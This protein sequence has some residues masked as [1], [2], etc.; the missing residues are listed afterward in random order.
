MATVVLSQPAEQRAYA[1]AFGL[2]VFTIL[3]N[4]TEGAVS[5]WLG[6]RDETLA[7]FGFGVDSFIEV[8]SGLGIAYMVVR[9]RRAPHSN[10]GRAAG[11]KLALRITG[12]GFYALVAGLVVSAAV[13]VWTGHRPE[14]TGWGVVISL[15]SIAVMWALVR[16][17]ERV[18]RQLNSAAIRAS[19]QTGWSDLGHGSGCCLSGPCRARA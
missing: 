9:L 19:S 8:I 6:F 4:L 5:T 14:T 15:V 7:L 17:K 16:A 12:Y 18:G 10:A 2:S 1:V 13:S 11:E 3:Y